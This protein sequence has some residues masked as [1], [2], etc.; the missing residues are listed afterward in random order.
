MTITFLKPRVLHRIKILAKRRWYLRNEKRYIEADIIRYKLERVGI[1][2]QDTGECTSIM[3]S[4]L[5][6]SHLI[7][8]ERFAGEGMEKAI[9]Q[10]LPSMVC[11]QNI[12]YLAKRYKQ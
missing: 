4:R 9:K 12:E 5:V 2:L 6:N 1:K 3:V 11:Y 7:D 8:W 10:Q